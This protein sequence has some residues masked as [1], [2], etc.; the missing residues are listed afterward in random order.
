MKR[1]R[2]SKPLLKR[3]IELAQHNTKSGM[4]AARYLDVSYNT[5]KKWAKLHG[6]FNNTRGPGSLIGKITNDSVT[7]SRMVLD[8]I[9]KGEYPKYNRHHFKLKLIQ[10]Q[11]LKEECEI[12]KFDE[13]RITDG[14]VP[15]V[16][17]Y[18][19]RNELNFAVENLQLVCFN[20]Y[21]LTYG[22]LTGPKREYI[23]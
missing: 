7:R 23:Y 5:Y 4:D 20:C 12:C 15:L 9:L 18:K 13:K 22:N 21:F 17:V 3:D 1:G 19:D 16:L 10:H 14:R 2:Y 8:K 6:L 11:V